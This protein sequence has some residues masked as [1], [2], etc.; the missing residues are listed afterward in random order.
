VEKSLIVIGAGIAGLSTGVYARLNGYRT[1]IF[2]QSDKPGGLCASWRRDGY[3]FSSSLY[4]IFGAGPGVDFYDI[5]SEIG[6]LSGKEI[7][8]FD[9]FLVV[10]LTGGRRFYM[11]SDL[12]RQEAYMK[13]LAPEDRRLIDEFLAGARAAAHSF[14]PQKKAPELLRPLE[15]I[16]MMIRHFRFLK[17]AV[18][19]KSVSIGSFAR[20]F[21]NP[22]LREAFEHIAPLFSD[23]PILIRQ[24]PLGLSH[25]GAIGCPV[26]GSG[27]FVRGILDRYLSL[28]GTICYRSPV[29]EILVE[30][31]RAVGVR[32]ET[33]TEH[34]ADTVVSA[35]DG[36]ATIYDL[37]G[38]RYLDRK[39]G[40][41]YARVPTATPCLEISLGVAR[42]FNDFPR[43][44]YGITYVLDPPVQVAGR[45]QKDFIL[46]CCNYDPTLAPPGKT[47]LRVSFVTEYEFWDA[48]RDDRKAYEEA[49]SE[50]LQKTV[51]LLEERIPGLSKQVEVAEV[52]TPL[53]FERYTRNWKGSPMGWELNTRTFLV[54][55]KKTLPKLQGFYMAGHWVEPGGGIPAAATSGRHVVQLICHSD[56]RPFTP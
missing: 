16:T 11:Y 38:D 49:K 34:R 27:D 32:L 21:K 42:S 47:Y 2:E 17:V 30:Q 18:K 31:D 43:S 24:V 12:D 3:T 4:F 33:G 51:E 44:A 53:T 1:I 48:L 7:A 56:G 20:R 55:M 10:E 54:P 35:A 13:Q 45:R 25:I 8:T 46:A 37:L 52:A 40:D 23:P 5:L 14:V 29:A 26:G 36:H 39:L 50:V 6:A 9:C 22:F 41:W 28:G 19:G 15:R